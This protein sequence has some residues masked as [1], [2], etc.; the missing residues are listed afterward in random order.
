MLGFAPISALP[1]ASLPVAV[2][3]SPTVAGG[4]DDKRKK[5]F[6]VKVGNRL[7]EY[8]SADAAARALDDTPSAPLAE[9]P[10]RTIK[11]QAR[12]FSAEQ[13]IQ[14]LFRQQDFEAMFSLYEQMQ[15]DDDAEA[16]LMLM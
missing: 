10:I 15:E 2:Q 1:L 14:D 13:K 11:A 6:V 8:G 16:L 4:Y 3:A 12:V 7:V 5:R 9:V